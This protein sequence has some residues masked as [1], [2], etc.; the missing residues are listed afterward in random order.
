MRLIDS[1]SHGGWRIAPSHR[2]SRAHYGRLGHH[3]QQAWDHRRQH[4][5]QLLLHVEVDL[6]LRCRLK[7]RSEACHPCH[8]PM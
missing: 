6:L 8:V 5:V 4:Q 3:A 2:A 7:S 1:L